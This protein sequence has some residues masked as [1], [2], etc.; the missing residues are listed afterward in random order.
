MAT[1]N[2]RRHHRHDARQHLDMDEPP[3]LTTVGSLDP[4]PAAEKRVP[5][6]MNDSLLPDMGRMDG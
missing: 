3:C 1:S 6:V 4:D 2:P 5:A